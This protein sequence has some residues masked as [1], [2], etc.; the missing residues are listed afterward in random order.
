MLFKNNLEIEIFEKIIL[1][2]NYFAEKI[3][4]KICKYLETC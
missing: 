4:A 3:V 2:K 1:F